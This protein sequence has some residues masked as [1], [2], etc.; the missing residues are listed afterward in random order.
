VTCSSGF[1]KQISDEI[2]KHI[3][4][5]LYVFVTEFE[6]QLVLLL[7][8]LEELLVHF[9]VLLRLQV[10]RLVKILHHFF[11]VEIRLILVTLGWFSCLAVVFI[12]ILNHVG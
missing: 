3:E 12:S 5:S 9:D 8:H 1:L 11:D 7:F 2:R 4:K 10:H 6:K